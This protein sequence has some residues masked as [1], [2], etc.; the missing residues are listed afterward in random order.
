MQKILIGLLA[1]SVAGC[2]KPKVTQP[3]MLGD[4]ELSCGQLKNAYAESEQLKKD[5]ESEKGWTGNNVARGILFW[6]AILGTRANADEAINAADS[7][8]IHLHNL[9]REKKCTN[10]SEIGSK[11]N[12]TKEKNSAKPKLSKN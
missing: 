10:I 8:M 5:A 3:I 4:Y 6:P 12:P 7:R 9:M 1:I 2:A 11:P